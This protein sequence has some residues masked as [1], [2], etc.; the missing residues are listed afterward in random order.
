MAQGL[1]AGFDLFATGLEHL[2]DTFSS[3][4]V[5]LRMRLIRNRNPLRK[6]DM[7]ERAA[8]AGFARAGSDSGGDLGLTVSRPPS[9]R[10]IFLYSR[11]LRA[12]AACLDCHGTEKRLNPEARRLLKD[13]YPQDKAVGFGE[14]EVMGA[15]FIRVGLKPARNL[16]PPVSN[17]R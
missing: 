7:V 10:R 11:E 14:G 15:L 2:Y 5:K 13:R 1:P 6:A 3:P 4:D 17:G 16:P 12:L 9:G 8:M